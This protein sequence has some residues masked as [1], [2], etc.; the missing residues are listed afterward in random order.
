VLA[1]EVDD[2]VEDIGDGR[3]RIDVAVG[4]QRAGHDRARAVLGR[5]E[6]DHPAC[7]A[8]A[9][10]RPMSLAP[11]TPGRAASRRTRSA[12]ERPPRGPP[13]CPRS[14][15]RR[16]R[17]GAPTT[18]R[19]EKDACGRRRR[20]TEDSH[21]VTLPLGYREQAKGEKV[22]RSSPAGPRPG[23]R[24]G[25]VIAGEHQQPLEL[26]L[27]RNLMSS[28]STPALLVDTHG[29]LVF[30]NDAAG[31][32]SVSGT[33]RRARWPWEEWGPATDRSTT[34]ATD[35]LRGD[36]ADDRAA[37]GPSRRPSPR[38][39]RSRRRATGTTSRSARCRW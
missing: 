32:C 15:L 26:I 11:S 36:A 29:V 31:T 28:L 16:R 20:Y 24:V 33:R 12:G 37:R 17:S 34:A 18:E 23:S 14:R 30:F 5:R 38:T 13:R 4:G 1:S 10:R 21:V 8:T 22:G 6:G 35:P 3:V 19:R 7:G 27:A 25:Y 9:H 2:R 39:I